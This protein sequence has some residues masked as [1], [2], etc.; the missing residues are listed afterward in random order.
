MSSLLDT[1]QVLHRCLINQRL[2]V[3]VT[4]EDEGARLGGGVTCAWVEV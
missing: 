4:L 2:S 3:R 1:P